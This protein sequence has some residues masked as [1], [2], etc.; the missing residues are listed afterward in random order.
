VIFIRKPLLLLLVGACAASLAA[1]GR[2]S[3]RLLFDTSIALAVFPLAQVLAFSA[4]YWTGGRPM[5]FA[6][7]VDTYFDGFWPWFLALAIVGT[8]GAVTTPIVAAQWFGRVGMACAVIA[9]AL[10]CRVDWRYSRDWLGR[11]SRRAVADVVVQ[12]TIGWSIVVVYM[13]MTAVPKAGS[14][15]PDVAANLF[16]PRP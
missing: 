1:G 3:L 5:R 11:G 6:T 4:V 12:R 14:F 15:L 13:L 7:A 2:F 10:S 9:L 16:G 8:F